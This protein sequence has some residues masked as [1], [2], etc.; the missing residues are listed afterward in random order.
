ME[1]FCIQCGQMFRKPRNR[2]QSSWQTAQFCSP[3]CRANG[4]VGTH[5]KPLSPKECGMCHII[6]TKPKNIDNA[7]WDKRIYCSQ[8]CAIKAR[9]GHPVS[10]E[11]KNKLRETSTGYR[12]SEEARRKMSIIHT[13]QPAWNKKSPVYL[14]C[15]HCGQKKRIK[16][17]EVGIAKYCSKQCA[18]Q[19][20]DHGKTKEARKIR[21]S[22]SYK[23]WRQQV[24]KRDNFTCVKCG[25]QEGTLNA[26][27]IKR[28][29]DF[30]ELRLEVTNGQTLC[31]SCHRQTPTFG[32]RGREIIQILSVQ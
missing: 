8:S 12:H 10:D 17:A 18:N 5:Y 23:K 22:A 11:T 15:M 1:K 14:L 2:S 28:F 6:F 30:P 4:R 20:S 29:A 16:W 26:D 21:T 9:M 19:H 13:G 32:N 25:Q 3:S 7:R 27:H 24:L 31:E